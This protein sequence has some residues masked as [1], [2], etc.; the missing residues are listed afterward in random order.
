MATKLA[1]VAG[2]YIAHH[3]WLDVE[4][5]PDTIH[6][7]G[8]TSDLGTRLTDSA[9]FTCFPDGWTYVATFECSS[10][11][12]AHRLETAV[13]HC[14]RDVRIDGRELVRL[15]SARLVALAAEVASTL[16]ISATQRDNPE[17]APG[18]RARVVAAATTAMDTN[19]WLDPHRARLETLTVVD[20]VDQYLNDLLTW[21]V[22][23]D[24][25]TVAPAAPVATVAPAALVTGGGV[26][27][28]TA[29]DAT[30][31]K[32]DGLF[33]EADDAIALDEALTA[34]TGSPHDLVAAVAEM[35]PRE[36]QQEAIAATLDELK[37]SGRTILQMAC[38]C[39]KTPVAYGVIQR[40]LPRAD[41]IAAITGPACA[42][43][44]V[45]GLSLLR[46]TAQKL[47]SYGF[48]DPMLLV[49]SDERPVP[50]PGGRDLHMTTD[51]AVIASFLAE[52]GRRLVIS[53][54]QSSPQVPTDAFAL[55]VFDESHRVCG[56]SAPRPFNHHITAP[57]VGARLFMTATPAYD[58][59]SKSPITMKNRDLFGGVAF[60]YHLRRGISA[61]YVNDFRLEIVAARATGPITAAAAEEAAP[62][63]IMAAMA[64][65]DKLLVFCR[66][67][68]HATRLCAAV[69]AA[70]VPAGVS[71]FTCSVA[72][73]KMGAGGASGALRT[74]SEP[75]SRSVLF[76]CRLFQE[77]VE[78]PSLNAV[79][80]AA[81]RHSARDIIQSVC[82][83][84]NHVEG[85]PP[86][87]IFLPV[88]HDPSRSPLDVENLNRY[89]SIV[90]FVDALLDEDPGLYEHLLDPTAAPYPVDILGT[91]TLAL[92]D[93]KSR[94][95]LLA[96]VRRAVR[97]GSSTS[98][99]PTE[100]LLRVENVP[101]DRAL[102]EIRRIV[103]T[104]GRYPKTT[105]AWV[106]GEA[107]VC[108]HRFYR[109][110]AD[111]YR[112]YRAGNAS[113]LEPHQINDLAALPHWDL[114]GVEGPYPWK[115]CIAFLTQWLEEH[116]GVPPM[117][118]INKG[119]YIGLEATAMERLSGALTCINQ[120]DGK[121]RANG[122]A[123][124][125]VSADK[126][127]DLDTLCARFGLRWR[128]D[129][130]A[131]GELIEGGPQSFIQEAFTRFKAYYKAHGSDGEYVKTWFSGYPLKHTRQEN[132]EV[133]QRGLAPPRMR[134]VRA[135]AA[136]TA[137]KKP[138]KKTE[139]A[140]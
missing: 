88:L 3:R 120:G 126:A 114:F 131:N 32:E 47:A 122:G 106:V 23:A 19:K 39:G 31:T 50:I 57:R 137:A 115:F 67:I 14:C 132:T 63:Q 116:K 121:K 123:G 12:I 65:V 10:A 58:P 93:A 127:A 70:A 33:D 76:N 16:D 87:V 4:S 110:A 11:D 125:T 44:L 5:G 128:K 9:Y 51:P 90:P 130:D 60:R 80:F 29:A 25:I 38:R 66:D 108:L 36:Y 54:Y 73:S 43:Y 42:L 118:E 40:Y 79:F 13:L 52:R 56:G 62:G 72:H 102:A 104:C 101:W 34:K 64:K 85:K 41:S 105:D 28:K 86:S 2:F 46:Q 69:A 97:Y 81:P 113:R 119:G 18:G 83:P 77:G 49:G 94:A 53:T 37:V 96:A 139:S 99:R 15:N 35:E 68:G 124:F 61:G 111:E 107:R 27:K 74:F 84:L 30:V 71:P 26:P 48:A 133:Q 117:V 7:V 21:D 78:I 92:G 103:T 109:A 129:R 136:K 89:A 95:A 82:R 8:F 17:Y 1:G 55:T 59:P 91:H 22:E 138:A 98:A 45:P 24:T 100:R 112:A 134:T 20:D 6:K 140:K 75:G 135:A